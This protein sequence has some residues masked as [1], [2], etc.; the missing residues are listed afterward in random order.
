MAASSRPKLCR[1]IMNI[2]HTSI[3][4]ST[5]KTA[6]RAEMFYDGGQYYI[7]KQTEIAGEWIL[8]PGL[9]SRTPKSQAVSP[10]QSLARKHIYYEETLSPDIL[11]TRDP[12]YT[13]RLRTILEGP[14]F[15]NLTKGT[16]GLTLDEREDKWCYIIIANGQGEPELRMY[17]ATN[18]G[19]ISLGLPVFA[20]GDIHAKVR[21]VDGRIIAKI[22]EIND[23]SG[24]YN[25]ATSK[26]L[27]FEDN[28]VIKS[29]DQYPTRGELKEIHACKDN[30]MRMVGINPEQICVINAGGKYANGEK[31]PEYF[32]IPK[33]DGSSA[34]PPTSQALKASTSAFLVAA[35]WDSP[36]SPI[37]TKLAISVDT[38]ASPDL[39]PLYRRVPLASFHP[40]ALP[41]ADTTQLTARQTE[42]KR[43][44]PLGGAPQISSFEVEAPRTSRHAPLILA[45]LASPPTPKPLAS[46]ALISSPRAGVAADVPARPMARLAALD[47]APAPKSP[48]SVHSAAPATTSA[49]VTKLSSAAALK[50]SSATFCTFVTKK[51]KGRLRIITA[52][53]PNDPAAKKY[54]ISGRR[55]T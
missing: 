10:I 31:Y 23:V 2:E 49:K 21:K 54:L 1:Y 36:P 5:F 40:A 19:V 9:G 14:S 50:A 6:L 53:A 32:S 7:A 52:D 34:L 28:S 20:S 39:S 26:V 42:R 24:G 15:A 13:A 55:N 22:Y 29:Q 25:P 48:Q 46:P 41:S 33:I 27:R 47:V 12:K 43:L 8:E 3:V 38:G 4:D 45:P 16:A 11:I 18:H 35:L 17:Q 51:D 30:V 37:A 44:P